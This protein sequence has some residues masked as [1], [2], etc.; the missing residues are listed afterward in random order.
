MIIHLTVINPVLPW[1]YIIIC[2]KCFNLLA[3]AVYKTA[4][5]TTTSKLN[6]YSIVSPRCWSYCR[7]IH[8]LCIRCGMNRLLHSQG[9]FQKCTYRAMWLTQLYFL[10]GQ[11]S[12]NANGKMVILAILHYCNY[13]GDSQ[14]CSGCDQPQP[15]CRYLRAS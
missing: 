11:T 12:I 8:N 13:L 3:K 7:H 9:P 5:Q 15:I 14:F 6:L 4:L 2:G 1:V 10:L